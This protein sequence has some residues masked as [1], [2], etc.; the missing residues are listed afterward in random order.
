MGKVEGEGLRAAFKD[1]LGKLV[2]I[3][4]REQVDFH[5]C[6]RTKNYAV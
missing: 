4:T 2:Q 5:L 1:S 3:S 6:R